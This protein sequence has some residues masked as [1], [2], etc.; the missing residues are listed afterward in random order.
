MNTNKISNIFTFL[1]SQNIRP[2]HSVPF[3]LR[4]LGKRNSALAKA[5]G[6][7]RNMFYKILAGERTPNE[8]VKQSLKVLGINPWE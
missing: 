2:I 8:N 6:I 4:L 7:T 3:C 1:A 5:A